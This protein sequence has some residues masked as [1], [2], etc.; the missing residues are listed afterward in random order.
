M[1]KVIISV[2]PSTNLYLMCIR[3]LQLD[4]SSENWSKL[5]NEIRELKTLE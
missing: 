1:V 3:M 4:C 2:A 5:R